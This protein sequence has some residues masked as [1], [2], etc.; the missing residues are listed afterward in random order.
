MARSFEKSPAITLRG[1]AFR[2]SDPASGSKNNNIASVAP[3]AETR[4][5]SVLFQVDG[6]HRAPPGGVAR[7]AFNLFGYLN[8]HPE[9]PRGPR[10]AGPGMTS[11]R[12]LCH[13]DAADPAGR[14]RTDGRSHELLRQGRHRRLAPDAPD[15]RAGGADARGL[16]ARTRGPH[17]RRRVPLR[18]RSG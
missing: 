5:G 1:M 6:A 9:G 12:R 18:A 3:P 8:P 14:P 13:H 15:A 16:P 17:R 11:A 10:E 7:G 4:Q 2:S